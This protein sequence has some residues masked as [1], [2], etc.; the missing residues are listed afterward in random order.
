M[1]FGVDDMKNKILLILFT[2]AAFIP[3]LAYAQ[4]PAP[5]PEKGWERVGW[6]IGCVEKIPS[7]MVIWLIALGLLLAAA[8]GWCVYGKKGDE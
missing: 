1:H 4:T 6:A 8:I 3:R 7:G 2:L 5:A